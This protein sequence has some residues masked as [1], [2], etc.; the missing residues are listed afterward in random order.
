MISQNHPCTFNK[1]KEQ[2]ASVSRNTNS[3]KLIQTDRDH[4]NRNI[5]GVFACIKHY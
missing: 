3:M 2:I 4:H 1:Y 5:L